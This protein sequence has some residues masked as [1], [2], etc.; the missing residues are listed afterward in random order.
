M[1]ASRPRLAEHPLNRAVPRLLRA[2]LPL[3]VTAAILF[4]ISRRVDVATAIERIRGDTLLVLLPALIAYGLSSL[5]IEAIS[6]MRAGS[7]TGR[8]LPFVSMARVKAASYPLGLLHYA[9]GAGALV[10]LLRRRAG[11]ALAEATGVV[12]LISALD[13]LALLSLAVVASAWLATEEPV[14]RLGVVVIVLVGAPLGLLALRTETSLGP[15]EPLRRLRVLRAARELRLAHLAQ[16]LAL[17]L[18]FVAT[19]VALGA[20]ALAAFGIHPRLGALVV[21]FAQIALVAAIPIAV[22]GLGTSQAAFLFVFRSLA[23]AA[24]LLACSVALSAGIIAVR[25]ALGVACVREFSRA[26]AAASGDA[27]V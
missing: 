17:R 1:G 12:V 7:E 10:V 26:P 9:L 23:P 4:E 15:L 8:A 27:D 16:L 24:E 18:L 14:L 19:F 25:I 13:L 2:L 20:A 21:G 5:C 22:A 6:L 3:A 11:L